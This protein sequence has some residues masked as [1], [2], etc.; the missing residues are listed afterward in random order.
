MMVV[1]S[2]LERGGNLCRRIIRNYY[3]QNNEFYR[4]GH[5]LHFST[6]LAVN[7]PL[8]CWRYGGPDDGD[9]IVIISLLAVAPDRVTWQLKM[10][11]N[12]KCYRE[13]MVINWANFR[14]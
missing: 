8:L 12:L 14:F 4:K 3:A 5:N 11:T 13:K 1:G 10:A 7:W 2:K 9:M 6:L